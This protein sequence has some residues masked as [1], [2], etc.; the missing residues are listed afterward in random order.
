MY[1]EGTAENWIEWV[2]R[3]RQ[4]RWP[5]PHVHEI[6]R[7]RKLMLRVQHPQMRDPLAILLGK[8]RPGTARHNLAHE[9]LDELDIAWLSV[10]DRSQ[11]RNLSDY[12]SQFA[13]LL[14]HGTIDAIVKTVH[15]TL[16]PADCVR[17]IDLLH[18]VVLSL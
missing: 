11:A 3:T 10:L 12:E 1:G 9:G 13:T 16:K 4:K 5:I 8:E 15:T 18:E 14:E 17:L 6:Q 7:Q 2:R